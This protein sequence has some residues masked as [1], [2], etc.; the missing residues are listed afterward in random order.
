MTNSTSLSVR[1]LVAAAAIALSSLSSI[2]ARA[3]TM[4]GVLS[5]FNTGNRAGSF[6][7]IEHGGQDTLGF[8]FATAS[9]HIEGV[10]WG[11][12]QAFGG[13]PNAGY[14]STF[15]CPRKTPCMIVLKKTHVRVQ[16]SMQDGARVATNITALDPEGPN[17]P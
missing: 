12:M 3:D 2:A 8:G 15:F 4:E 17:K 11:N 6:S 16:Y 1:A 9:L 7:L 10:W 13:K 14:F 5:D